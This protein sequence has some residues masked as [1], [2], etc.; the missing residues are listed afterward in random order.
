M[1]T[2]GKVIKNKLELLK[3]LLCRIHQRGRA[4]LSAGRHQHYS[5]IGLAKLYNRKNVLVAADILNDRVIP[6]FRTA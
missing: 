3:H 5:K 6:F 2:K 1:T 4:Y